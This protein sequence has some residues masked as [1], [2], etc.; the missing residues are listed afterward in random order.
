M[1]LNR[2]GGYG[3]KSYGLDFMPLQVL[4]STEVPLTYS[5]SF[6]GHILYE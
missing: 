2:L 4:L 6:C 5:A 3:E 1:W